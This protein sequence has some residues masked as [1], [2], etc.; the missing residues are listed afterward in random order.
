MKGHSPL[1][2]VSVI[3]LVQIM[4]VAYYALWL[5]NTGDD[6]DITQGKSVHTIGKGVHT[7]GKSLL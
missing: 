3:H 7:I 5:V 6:T 2:E 1:S 4:G